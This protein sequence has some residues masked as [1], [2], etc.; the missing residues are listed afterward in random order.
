MPH[1]VIESVPKQLLIDGKWV[2]AGSGATLDV[3]NPATG[4]VVCAVADAAPADG[5]LALE[6]A[7]AAQPAFAATTP[8]ERHEMLM[9]AFQLLHERIDELA[10]LMTTEMGKPLAESRGEIG[11]AAEFL[12]HFAGEALRIDGGYQ[13]APQG[14]ARFLVAKQPVGPCLLITPWNFPMA[15]GTR[16]LGPAIAAGCTSVIKPA[17]QTPLSMLALVE[18]LQ[19][20]GVPDGWSTA[21]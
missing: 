3:H 20:A 16:K 12:R 6:A 7:V 19:E 14:G 18:I 13:A 5:R 17:S 10:L 2:D 15:M 9:K 8:L 21:W 1:P 4:E 11:Y